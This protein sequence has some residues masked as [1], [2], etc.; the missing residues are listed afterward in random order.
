MWDTQSSNPLYPLVAKCYTEEGDFSLT[1]AAAFNLAFGRCW[2][3]GWTGMCTE[4]SA[5]KSKS[6]RDK[7]QPDYSGFRQENSH[8]IGALGERESAK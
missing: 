8:E 5:F 7:N 4:V 1:T 3:H 2:W 6:S